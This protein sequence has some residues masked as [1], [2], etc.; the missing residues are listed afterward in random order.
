MAIT[1][2]RPTRWLSVTETI[3]FEHRTDEE[4]IAVLTAA[5]Y[6]TVAGHEQPSQR[7]E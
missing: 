6:S 7:V 2:A 3:E 4:M 5:G 1:L